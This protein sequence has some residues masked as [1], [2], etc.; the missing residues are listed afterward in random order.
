MVNPDCA[1][2]VL[3]DQLHATVEIIHFKLSTTF[4][5]ISS[6]PYE[7]KMIKKYQN[8][9]LLLARFVL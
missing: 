7:Q 9:L 8:Y 3:F 4:S 2:L 5:E 1:T 6:I